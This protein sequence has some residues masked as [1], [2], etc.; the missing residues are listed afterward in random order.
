ML[1]KA[2]VIF[3]ATCGLLVA[4]SANA[5]PFTL[6]ATVN[7]SVGGASGTVDPISTADFNAL[8]GQ[9]CTDL[10]PSVGLCPVD[11]TGATDDVVFFTLTVSS[12]QIDEFGVSNPF[13]NTVDAAGIFT[14]PGT[15]LD[16]GVVQDAGAGA[17]W[18]GGDGISGAGTWNF[19]PGTTEILFIAHQSGSLS[20]GDDIN[21]MINPDGPIDVQ[22]FLG[23]ITTIPEPATALLLGLG[24]FS[25]AVAG[26][27]R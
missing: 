4:G 24:F 7:W 12:G 3:A 11:Q 23:T 18:S 5:V 14:S 25:I 1:R 22:N 8:A 9:S 27:R 6:S 15:G 19:G 17:I 13:P 26:R 21:F 2:A 10:A 20:D 16:P